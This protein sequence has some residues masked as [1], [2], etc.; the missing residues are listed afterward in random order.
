MRAVLGLIAMVVLAG[1][2]SSP[3]P[4]A[5]TSTAPEAGAVCGICVD[6]Q[7]RPVAA[8]A[9]G[10]CPLLP[11]KS[12]S[13]VMDWDSRLGTAAIACIDAPVGQCT[14]YQ[15]VTPDGDDWTA[16]LPS[17]N[18]TAVDVALTWTA[19]TPAT[20]ALGFR[21]MVMGACPGCNVT[22]LGQVTGTSPLVIQKQGL[23][24]PGG[25]GMKLHAYAWN[26]QGLVHN[27]PA[28]AYASADQALHGA[29]NVTVQTA[30]RAS[31]KT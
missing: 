17:G 3:P 5:P 21:I 25:P 7:V 30:T 15:S 9:D 26:Q 2:A 19:Q 29:G 8:N 23:H 28:I 12:S 13:I 24:I 4:A 11:P 27:P 10:S 6:D 20:Q 22:D 1:C 16:P 14:P 31:T 18:V